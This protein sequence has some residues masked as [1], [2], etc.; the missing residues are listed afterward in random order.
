MYLF[1]GGKNGPQKVPHT[2]TDE[3]DLFGPSVTGDVGK[4]GQV[5]LPSSKVDQQSSNDI[6]SGNENGGNLKIFIFLF[7]FYF[8]CFGF[9]IVYI[10][11]VLLFCFI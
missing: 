4:T 3:Q 8:Y 7:I 6:S 1:L 11:F 2:P 10:F 5:P 9:F